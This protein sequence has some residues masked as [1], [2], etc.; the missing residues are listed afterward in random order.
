MSCPAQT[1]YTTKKNEHDFRKEDYISVA[2][3][4][5]F[6]KI[7]PSTLRN[8]SNEGKITPIRLE[9]GY[10]FYKIAELKTI[11]K[12]IELEHENNK[13]IVYP[14][15][16]KP[17]NKETKINL[18][19]IRLFK[20]LLAPE[21]LMLG[22]I[23]FTAFSLLSRA[24]MSNYEAQIKGSTIKAGTNN[25]LGVRDRI[26]NFVY[27]IN[28]PTNIK[29]NLTVEGNVT[30][31]EV[32][33]QGLALLNGL[34]GIDTITKD[35]LE[36][37][38]GING[39]VTGTELTNVKINNKAIIQEYLADN[40]NYSGKWNFS[41]SLALKGTTLTATASQLNE[42]ATNSTELI[43][44]TNYAVAL[45]NLAGS[46]FES[47][48]IAFGDGSKYIQ[49]TSSLFWN[50]TDKRLGINN[51]NPLYTIDVTGSI[52]ASNLLIGGT[53]ITAT[54]NE[55][56]YLAGATVTDGGIVFGNGTALSQDISGLYW[57]YTDN[58]LGIA[59]TSP[60]YNLDVNGSTRV[61]G[62]V[63]IGGNT[64][65]LI[66]TT[67]SNFTIDKSSTAGNLEIKTYIEGD[68]NL[69]PGAG[70]QIAL[71]PSAE[72]VHIEG[73]GL[74][75][76]S[77][78]R[79]LVANLASGIVQIGNDAGISNLLNVG[80]NV[81][82]GSYLYFD[83]TTSGSSAIGFR[84]NSGIMQ[85]KNS[86]G[87]WDD[88][89]TSGGL[90]PEGT[91]GA[92]QFTDG[93][94]FAADSLNFNWNDAN[95]YLTLASIRGVGVTNPL[96][97]KDHNGVGG[98]TVASGGN[99]GIFNTYPNTE[100][101]VTGSISAS[102][103][104]YIAGVGLGSTAVLPYLSGATRIGIASGSLSNALTATNVQEALEALDNIVGA[105]AGD[106]QGI[107]S[108]ASGQA[109]NSIAT[110][111]GQWLGLG[112]NDGRIAFS[113][114]PGT[115]QIHLL[116]ANVGIG[117]TNAGSLLEVN[118]EIRGTRFS[119]SNNT[120]NYFEYTNGS[121]G[122]G[123]S[124]LT[125]LT[126]SST[127]KLGI[128]TTSP[129]ATL[130]IQATDSNA[131]NIKNYGT[132]S[133]ETGELKFFGTNGSYVGFKAPDSAPGNQIYILPSLDGLNDQ[134][135]STDGTGKLSWKTASGV[136]TTA[137]GDIES[138]GSITSGNAFSDASA[139]NQWFGL[140]AAAGRLF[141]SD[142][143]IDEISFLSA[144]IGI[145]TTNPT[146]LLDVNGA[147]KG[148]SLTDGTATL[149]SGAVTGLTNLT[150]SGTLATSG[151]IDLGTNTI[152]DGFL[153]GNWNFSNG[154]LSGINSIGTT[155]ITA[156]GTITGSTINGSTANLATI[157]STNLTASGTVTLSGIASTNAGDNLINIDA[158]GKLTY[159]TID[160]RSFGSS[161][162]DGS[163]ISNYL[164][165]WF[166][167]N[168]LTTGTIY[169]NGTNVGVGTTDVSAAKLTVNGA[170][171]GTTITGTSLTDGTATLTSGAITGLT[172]LTM[173]G[174]LDLGTNTIYDGF[175]TGNWNFT[176]AALSGINSI[177]TTSITASGTI[178]GSTIN[179]T[180]ANLAT[181]GSTNITSTGT[182]TGSTANLASISTT[183]ITTTGT[184][185]L[186][187]LGTGSTST[188][189]LTLN[190]SNE[191]NIDTAGKLGYR[192][193]DSRIF[194]S[195]LTDGSGVSNYLTRWLDVNTLTSG[196]IYDN[197]TSIGLGT[198]SLISALNITPST[199]AGIQ[200]NPSGTNPADMRFLDSD[201]SNYTGFKAPNTLAGNYVYTLPS[202][203][204]MNNYVLA[205]DSVGNLSWQS[206]TGVGAGTIDGS[207]TANY[208]SI[209]VD[210]D[211]LSAGS[212][213]D[214]G[215]RLGIG[216]T[217]LAAALNITSDTINALQI[218]PSGTNP[219]ELRFMD[220]ASSNYTGFK[221]PNTIAGNYIYTLPSATGMNNYVLSTD[222][223]G[224]LS[225]KSVT[226]V[227]AGTIDGSG[228][229][230]Y[231]S[232]W[233]DADTLGIGSIYDNGTNVGIGTTNPL[234][235]LDVN[236]T[237]NGTTI[238]GTSL[239]DGTAT[240]TSGTITGLTSMTMSGNLNTSGTIDLGTNTIYDGF[241]TGNWDFTNGQLSSI[242]SIGTTSITASGTVILSG[243]GST[244]TGTNVVTVDGSG[245]LSYRAIDSR[246]FGTTLTDGSGVSNYIT[247]WLDGDT[248]TT[249]TIYDNGTNVGI[250]TTAPLKG[251][252]ITVETLFR[253]NVFFATGTTYYVDSAGNAVFKNLSA[254]GTENPFTGT[255][256]ITAGDG[257]S[258]SLKLGSSYITDMNTPYL[259][260]HTGN[261]SQGIRIYDNGDTWLGNGN[262]GI[263]TTSPLYAL[264]V[265]GDIY[266]SANLRANTEMFIGGIGLGSTGTS[267]TTSGAS[268]V[269]TF[270]EFT[271]SN[272]TT[273]QA[274]LND[275]DNELLSAV[276]N[277]LTGTGP[278]NYL[279]KYSA[280]SGVLEASNILDNGTN[281]GIG[282]T[283][284]SAAKLTVNG[285]IKGTTITGTSL[286]DG[287]ATLTSGAITGLTNLTMSGTLD[288][289][290]N[291]IYDGFLT[292]NW[293]FSNGIIS[294]VN[295]IGTTSITASGTI[296]GSTINGSTANLATI[297]S[298]NIT[299]T[300]TIS[301][302]TINGSTAN[303]AT[304]GS[305]NLTAT[306]TV[307]L[308]GLSASTSPFIIGIN[309]ATGTLSYQSID[310]RILGTTLVDGSGISNYLSRWLDS[311]TLT[312]GTLYDNGTNIG[313]GTTD[314]SAAKLTVN[315]AIKGTTITGTSLTDGT[316][317]LTSGA[318]T[319]LTN[320]TMSG[321]IDL[322]T[323]TIYD[324]FLTGNWSFTNGQ[325]SGINSIGTTSL[326]ASGTITGSTI[327]G[328]TANLA[329]IGSTNLTATGTVTL[330]GLSASTSPFIMGINTATG[331]L[332]YQNIDTRILGTTLVDGSGISNYLSRWLD[333]N[334]L[335][336]GTLYD[337]GTN[338]GVG[339]TDVSAAKLTVNGAIKGT[340]I[341]GTS[342]TDGTAT[343]TSGAITGLTNLTMS[344]TLDLGTNTIYDGFLTGNW[345]FTNGQLSNINSIGTTSLTA[346]GT[347]TGSTINGS[348]ANL[349]TIGSTNLTAT[350]SVTLSGLTSNTEPF[351]I[352]INTS[353]GALS[354][355]NIDTRILGTTLVDGSGISNYLT[356]WLDANTLTTG[357]MYD[358][359][360]N[361][362]IG[363]T[364]PLYLLSI[365]SPTP[366]IAFTETDGSTNNKLWKVGPDG[367]QFVFQA[368][369][370]ANGI[371]SDYIGIGRTGGQILGMRFYGLGNVTNYISTTGNNFFNSGNVGIGTTNPSYKLDVVGTL[372]SSSTVNLTGLSAVANNTILGINTSTGAVNYQ[373]IDSRV[374]GTTL[375]GSSNAIA[376]YVPIFYGATGITNSTI[377]DNSGYVGIGTSAAGAKLEIENG[378]TENKISLLLD[379]NDTTNNPD[380]LVIQNAGTGRAIYIDSGEF[381][382][383]STGNIT[384]TGTT[385]ITLNASADLH[386][387]T[388]GLRDIGTSSTSSGAYLIGFNTSLTSSGY[389]TTN[390]VQQA[391]EQ[392]NTQLGNV[393]NGYITE[394]GSMSSGAAFSNSSASGQWL[395]LGATAGRI[396]FV[397]NGTDKISI[398][399]AYLGVGIS[400][401]LN[402]LDVNGGAVIGGNY[403]GVN[404]AP[405]N[406]LLVQGS[407]GVGTTATKSSI[408]VNGNMVIGEAFAGITSA[409]ANGLF[410]Q[411]DV[412]IGNS[413]NAYLNIGTTYGDS[414][415]GFKSENGVMKF[416]N[417]TGSWA[418]FGGAYW[419]IN[420]VSTPDTL[421]LDPTYAGSIGIGTTVAN[422]TLELKGNALLGGTSSTQGLYI[423][424]NGNV[425][426]GT[427]NPGY[428][429]DVSGVARVASNSGF[430]KLVL[431]SSGSAPYLSYGSPAD[432]FAFGDINS[433]KLVIN[434]ASGNVG[435]GTTA[436][437]YK[438]DL[439][440]TLRTN[441]TVNFTGLSATANN[442]ILGIDTSTGAVSYQT[443]DA[444]AL[445]T[446]LTDGSGVSNYLSRWLDANTLTTSAIYDDG[447]NIGIGTTTPTEKL[448]INGMI[449]LSDLGTTPAT[450]T[451]RLYQI[452]DLLYWE[453]NPI[454]N[455]TS[456]W[457]LNGTDI[458]RD[459]GNVGIGT[460]NP[461]LK[462]E[463]EGI[464]QSIG[465]S[466]SIFSW[467]NRGHV[468]GA[469]FGT[470]GSSRN[471]AAG[472]YLYRYLGSGTAY[473]NA[474]M[475]QAYGANGDLGLAFRTD[476]LAATG[477]TIATTTR[478][479][480]ST[481]GNIGIG[482]TAPLAQLQVSASSLATSAIMERTQALDG[483]LSS[484]L[485]VLAQTSTSSPSNNSGSAIRFELAGSGGTYYPLGFFGA[486]KDTA[487]NSGAVV[488][489]NYN[490]G[491]PRE[492]FRADHLGNIGIG[493]TNPTQPL[494]IS[495][496]IPMIGLEE[497][498]A[499]A[500]NKN[501]RIGPDGEDFILQALNDVY[502][503]G[504][505]YM[506]IT[507]TN[508][509]L[510]AMDFYNG[511]NLKNRISM[512][513]DS[514]F[515]I[516][517]V[518]I[519]IT[520]P[521]SLLDVNGRI[522]QTGSASIAGYL[523]TN[524]NL[525]NSTTNL[526][527][528][529][530]LFG[531]T[532]A[533]AQN[534]YGM[535][536][537]YNGAWRTRIFTASSGDIAFSTH[538]L[539][540][541]PTA[542]SSFT[543]LMVI[544]GS[545][546][547]GI[548]TTAPK[549]RLDVFGDMVIGSY[550]GV[551]TAPAN[552]LLVSGYL[553]VNTTNPYY[554]FDVSNNVT[555]F[556]Q[557][558]RNL[559]TGASA[560][561][562]LISIGNSNPGTSN[563]FIGFYASNG[564]NNF[565]LDSISGD[566]AYG[567]RYTGLAAGTYSDRRLKE[568]IQPYNGSALDFINNL[569]AV[570]FNYKEGTNTNLNRVGYIAQDML[571][572]YPQ[573]VNWGDDLSGIAEE[574]LPKL[575][576]NYG[577]LT[578]MLAE[579]IKELNTKVEGILGTDI[580]S[581]YDQ[582]LA[583][584][585]DIETFM[586][587]L[588]LSK[589]A[590]GTLLID[591]GINV[592]G[593]ASLK[594]VSVAGKFTVGAISLDS[595]NN[596][597]EILGPSCGSDVALC[598]AQ[599]L[600]IQKNIAGNIDLLDGKV[601]IMTNGDVKVTGTIEAKKVI[602]EEYSVMGTSKI[603]GDGILKAGDTK[604][605]INTDA[606]KSNSKVFLIATTS[607]E[608]KTLF[609]KEKVAGDHF[610][611]EISNSISSDIQ[612]DWFIM[613]VEE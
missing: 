174:T 395:G 357:V 331:T 228:T 444:R 470:W 447:T 563:N 318:I 426:V 432:S 433:Y 181:I 377:Y 216:T 527:P 176:N 249:S 580:T 274:V 603:I 172:N 215:T 15:Y 541:A 428:V 143:T 77:T 66:G 166:D 552:S 391:L 8:L 400:S 34:R 27:N 165:R 141:F 480:I 76:G 3:A 56:S 502:G 163:G 556:V 209:W 139:D 512:T 13:K 137:T 92:V 205:T 591:N 218:N 239:S 104:I 229:T 265:V 370:D 557:G 19:Y 360:T 102:S 366:I 382:V 54:A 600:Y 2:K 211:T 272:G 462:F 423:G 374:F 14:H 245:K 345:S 513:G 127:G 481:F 350:G 362:G 585:T 579:A 293:N 373:A 371:G 463:V 558:V 188:S 393:L 231:A 461:A 590:D 167:A 612:F 459:T 457:T 553:G 85:V 338:V 451:D 456:K 334:T 520:V 133:G 477:P 28:V 270:D 404:I 134:V 281:I 60:Q 422:Y 560:R 146:S 224:N 72:M 405:T 329:T 487:D 257:T 482:T 548:G 549:N 110:A 129:D 279:T 96:T 74:I 246:T 605:T 515:N 25:I 419:T 84:S 559:S 530:L 448:D 47:G 588:G 271:Y 68:I 569:N 518:G 294:G 416:K 466:D 24:N 103:E 359:G 584:K 173:S 314:V 613:N 332:S 340:T 123:T 131:L 499:S 536:L 529:V 278:T 51:N 11:Q 484:A 191:I 380:A 312:T 464:D 310:T 539:S 95:N 276:S 260:L 524:S 180:T 113:T 326:T 388:I 535:D 450:T 324:G 323:N 135:L 49:D 44:L 185:T 402:R 273:V 155:S 213:Y 219:A 565:L 478:M 269:G 347:I 142:D 67:G 58:R 421:Y 429:F 189:V 190:A 292:G 308:S 577:E 41:G 311:N 75:V 302:S 83:N 522:M 608:D 299:S 149:T 225:W 226:G 438:L 383:D 495:K 384:T 267:N 516:G 12:T 108:I 9:N 488:I 554:Q 61:T 98:I 297:G 599:T 62:D 320:L 247:R 392:V 114:A 304:I 261:T 479:Y 214:N 117:T 236:G 186:T 417:N 264:S 532:G 351:I 118:G 431:S 199:I 540:T 454:S 476:Y 386:I 328:S 531:G 275:L 145:G 356:R 4:A 222:A 237:I 555:T 50:N 220:S 523:M 5:E 441:N 91:T 248:V 467:S 367:Q 201:S 473:S 589:A 317:T 546:N 455:G 94:S 353:T 537:G 210:G 594:D 436:P 162:I 437:Q 571:K 387:G 105:S 40:I 412:K 128:G 336:T 39:D 175:L 425:G 337:N 595:I 376:N 295:S 208:T 244:N 87:V 368:G 365:N 119:F 375:V 313:V 287:T 212:L 399:N 500:N 528:G 254:T 243:I 48:G 607:T 52:N 198:T 36:R 596:S 407:L 251:L 378:P 6:L 204:G 566:S 430:G 355:Q 521:R 266:A 125:R 397:A 494:T 570:T 157:G 217:S 469:E 593:L 152:Y 517:N 460:T 471:N 184:V 504:G 401:P 286:T 385:G 306:G 609:I 126:I 592:T 192:A 572:V 550:A 452:A 90:T 122:I 255:P 16:I 508:E 235:K 232:I 408:D 562:T 501:W 534:F 259:A 156:S 538:P 439:N 390:N 206:V 414:G 424:V 363:T 101:D 381:I 283:D 485:R 335:T 151:T 263:G 1:E 339:T 498:D 394:V 519:G 7:S 285:A 207:G 497:S 182:I 453:G 398:L 389:I 358:N 22:I 169:D 194:G 158:S 305:T 493:T 604:V 427:T 138:V 443:I 121:I 64:L 63:I 150:M 21:Y 82:I 547:V 601:Q 561:G 288:L 445:G 241:L 475:G 124:G 364:A 262:V 33:F 282:T 89:A 164:S 203:T 301:G 10:R 130:T 136:G 435:I 88:I 132:G 346:S 168:T 597:I 446:T 491:T 291:T 81:G 284:L 115:S 65:A 348:T 606:I 576:F 490:A 578:P 489:Y 18:D 511:G 99:I 492:V 319:G 379:Q 352:G 153:T 45:I 42:L 543:D 159:R 361:I 289:G 474:F 26:T 307:T 551:N 144:N 233:V 147:I 202:S 31:N 53:N 415:Y 242:N 80:G 333:E 73:N 545:G 59:N 344:G 57:N 97:L 17:I 610:T 290:T 325:L 253:N 406:G 38:M 43:E 514:F 413:L 296:T 598:T 316:A 187:N 221:A 183:N 107:G 196:A 120:N 140:G 106:I 465:V 575:N 86:S 440:G 582:V 30:A 506:T 46:T 112:S 434:A 29:N 468:I 581:L 510:G 509:Q 583:V 410:V 258:G 369:T 100:L 573:A 542:Q 418:P 230:N 315:G 507:R 116:G 298:T 171:K 458:Y 486:V 93:S 256:S 227:G 449:K 277:A 567:T 354:Y 280:V 330:S 309:T 161:L 179:G 587:T 240:L 79:L 525:L 197:G 533:G 300:G 234:A 411:G 70:G 341:T 71:I 321:T 343:L 223:T 602:T 177:G 526:N 327:N 420:T 195:S 403:A 544:K 409:P 483:G 268:K 23:A 69:I 20:K 568:N 496:A 472:M 78:A 586:S 111:D 200:L 55:L 611:V 238:T 32:N 322:G 109:F 193:T 372:R 503:G 505:N 178:T 442:T 148:T 349:A 252:D 250:G 396:H 303:L 37:V 342:L 160:A 35:T 154:Q 564:T 574:D 170:I